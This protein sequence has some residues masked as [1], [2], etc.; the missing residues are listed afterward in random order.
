M[1]RRTEH[2][3]FAAFAS[4][5]TTKTSLG[6]WMHPSTDPGFLSPEYYIG[7]A[8]ELERGGVDV[9]FFDDRLAMPVA[10][11]ASTD[12]AVE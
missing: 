9:L 11:G 6:A 7:L 2:M 10:Y 5:S 12:P 1:T 8:Q 4:A 3:I